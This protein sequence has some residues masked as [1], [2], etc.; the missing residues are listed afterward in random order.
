MQY[1]LER[2][3]AVSFMFNLSCPLDIQVALE[4]RQL[5]MYVKFVGQ[6]VA[7]NVNFKV[8]GLKMFF[9]HITLD[10]VIREHRKDRKNKKN[11][12]EFWGISLLKSQEKEQ[13]SLNSKK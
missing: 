11:K 3:L 7:K 10:E 5:K 6:Y 13:R 4:T 12:D 2:E 8:L 1:V 9:K